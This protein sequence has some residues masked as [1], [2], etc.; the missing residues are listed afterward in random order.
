VLERAVERFFMTKG[1]GEGTGLGLSMAAVSRRMKGTAT[2]SGGS[3]VRSG[4]TETTPL[5][6]RQV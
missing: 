3:I 1:L 5:R 6:P 2:C 4:Q